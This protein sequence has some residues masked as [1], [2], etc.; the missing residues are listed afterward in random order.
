M[1]KRYLTKNEINTLLKY[2]IEDFNESFDY[3]FSFNNFV[4]Q[5]I[6]GGENREKVFE[7]FCG[8]YFPFRLKDNY[9][10]EEYFNFLAS[11]FPGKNK[12]DKQGVLVRTDIKSDEGEM[13]EVMLHEL[14]HIYCVHNECDGKNFYNEYC[15][16]YAK[17]KVTDGQINA[18]YA[19]WREF[20][21]DMLA[22][23]C[24]DVLPGYYL[25]EK[26]EF[27]KELKKGI[28][29]QKAKKLYLSK[30]LFEIMT[31][32]DVSSA[33]TWQKAKKVIVATK[34]FDVPMY[35]DLIEIVFRKVK[36]RTI[37]IDL[38][39]IMKLGFLYL[40][41]ITFSSIVGMKQIYEH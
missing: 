17:D 24:I 20:I 9:T 13:Y 16:S 19:V 7:E 31:S 29:C 4:I 25:R 26:K 11:A 18:G 12:T 5:V 6:D 33:D 22:I 8:T 1:N 35:M 27:L 40:E 23:E 39:F 32:V 34:I 41:I 21:A 28:E 36:A 14:A 2:A 10:S 38:D 30:L 15:E 3:D 37:K